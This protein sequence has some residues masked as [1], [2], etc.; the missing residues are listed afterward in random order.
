M[1]LK[2]LCRCC[3]NAAENNACCWSRVF[4]RFKACVL[5]VR[6]AS[7]NRRGGGFAPAQPG[8]AASASFDF[9]SDPRAPYPTKIH[10]IPI[11]SPSFSCLVHPLRLEYSSIPDIPVTG[12]LNEC[13]LLP[14]G[15]DEEQR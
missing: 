14:A 2:I 3:G 11:E 8:D 13:D 6:R 4:P 7:E 10:R 9:N 1:A 12:H 5:S 15:S